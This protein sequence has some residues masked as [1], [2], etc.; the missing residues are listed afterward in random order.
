MIKLKKRLIGTG[1]VLATGILLSACGQSNTD[2]STYSSTFSANPT[3]FNYLLD[4][5]ADNTAVITNLVDGL[6]END[7]YGNLVPAL[8][9][10]WSVSS[11]G[12]TY[13][14]KLRKD[15]KWYTADGEE[16]A[17]VK[18]QDF[19]TGIKYAADNKGQAMDLIQNSIKGLNDYVTGV[20]ND[21]STVGVKALDDYTVEY[22]LTRPEP[23]WNSK[24]T[25]SILFPV[26]EEF[27]KS[28]DKDF[29]TLTPDSILYNGPYLLK[30]FT[31]KS[32]IEYVKNP[33]Y[34]DHDK[35][36]IEKVKLAY[37]DGSDQEMTIR[38]FESG[39][40]SIAGV[41]PNSSNYAKTK[42][43]YQ[44]NIVYSLQ[45]KTSWYFNFNVN[46]K[47]YNHTAKTTD[48][49]K[50]S[51]QTAILN[52]NFRQ[53][54]NFGID[55]TAY[56]A[57]SNGEEAASKTLRNTLV[58]PTFV[59]VG[60]KTFGEVTASKLVDYGTEWSGI[61]LADA[62]D[63]YFNKE[64]AQAKFAEAK[65]ELEAQGVTFPIH[66][67]VPVDQTN[68]NAVSGM[69]SVKQTLETV[70]GSDNIVIDVQQLSTDDFGNVAFL[71][72]NPAARDYDLNFDGWVGDYQDPSTYLD[73]FNAETGF[74]L[75]IFGL[76]A[77]EDQELIKSLGLDTYTQLLKEADAENKDV[78]KRYEKYA[79][80][81][82]WMID[83]SLVMSAMSN[84]GTASVTKVTPFTRAYSLVG[85][86]GDGNNYKYIS[87]QKDPVTKKQFDEAKAK[88]EEES[89]KAIEKSQ[90]EFENHVK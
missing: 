48:E 72:P 61:N 52:K 11:D 15:A 18:A 22:T 58:P 46:R 1:L 86:K 60:D 40:Y 49:Q 62:Q 69:N 74:Y 56:S 63:A 77:K 32:S 55:R 4:Y 6:L 24:T 87:L 64:K 70:L 68:K 37:F 89:K 45:D 2:T 51:A 12:L 90:K 47:T 43:K 19:V 16:Y 75:K 85:I 42:E 13:T 34:Y 38:N 3:T 83:N 76:D 65:K 7:S 53:A 33:H 36:T 57:Q 50:K 29:G 54:I 25:N 35:V 41:Y 23:Y 8:A 26:N 21:F 84:G 9:E 39:A 73:P 10:D 88:W 31:S 80:A 14:Y 66:L 30:D 79:E 27:L 28:K 67:D 5:Y 71:A 44:D 20:T 59:Q 82:A 81:Q 78:A 17:S